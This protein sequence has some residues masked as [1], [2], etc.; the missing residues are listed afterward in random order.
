MSQEYIP[1]FLKMKPDAAVKEFLTDKSTLE[2]T[3]MLGELTKFVLEG[4]IFEFGTDF[5]I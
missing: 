1:T 5:F 2:A 3:E 4:N